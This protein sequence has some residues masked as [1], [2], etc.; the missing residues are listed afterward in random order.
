M[1]TL[2]TAPSTLASTSKSRNRCSWTVQERLRV[3][4]VVVAL[5]RDLSVDANDNRPYAI[6][7]EMTHLQRGPKLGRFFRGNEDG[8]PRLGIIA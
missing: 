7:V 3:G 6:L 4:A 1:D 2:T 8:Q 5:R